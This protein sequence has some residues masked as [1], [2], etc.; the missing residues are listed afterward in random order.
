[1]FDSPVDRE[2]EETKKMRVRADESL[3]RVAAI[4]ADQ[5]NALLVNPVLHAVARPFRLLIS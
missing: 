4:L 3:C 1:M 2:E 5:R